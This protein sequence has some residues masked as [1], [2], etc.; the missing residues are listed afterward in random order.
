M[1]LGMNLGD[2]KTLKKLTDTSGMK[3]FIGF[4]RRCVKNKNDQ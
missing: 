1:L 3:V 2:A 4:T